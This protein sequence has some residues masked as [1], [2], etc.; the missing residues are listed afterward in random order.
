ML[1]KDAARL[2]MILART[3]EM[4]DGHSLSDMLSLDVEEIDFVWKR[5][6]QDH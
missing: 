1:I 6:N 2:M 4:R 5:G 3:L